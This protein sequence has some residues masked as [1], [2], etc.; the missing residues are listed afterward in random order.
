M[1]PLPP[2]CRECA[3]CCR[4]AHDGRILV[5]EHDL[6]RWRREARSAALAALVPGHFGERALA[7]TAGGA[8]VHLGTAESP[9]D[10]SLYETR[11]ES[12]RLLE[13]GSAECLAYVRDAAS[14][15]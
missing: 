12:C 8:C 11:P 5:L 15:E 1:S 4:A 6:V 2:S 7:A 14:A 3:A 10:C 13:A 9:H